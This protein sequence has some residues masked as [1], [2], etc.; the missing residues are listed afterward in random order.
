LKKDSDTQVTITGL[1]PVTTPGSG[2]KITVAAEAQAAQAAGVTVTASAKPVP[3]VKSVTLTGIT[4]PETGVRLT[5]QVSAPGHIVGRTGGSTLSVA[6]EKWDESN[7]SFTYIDTYAKPSAEAGT[8]GEVGLHDV[9]ICSRS[10]GLG[11]LERLSSFSRRLAAI[12]VWG[13]G[14]NIPLILGEIFKRTSTDTAGKQPRTRPARMPDR[15]PG[16]N[17]LFNMVY[18]PGFAP[19]VRWLEDGFTAD[20]PSSGAARAALRE[21][22]TADRDKEDI[23]IANLEPLLTRRADGSVTFLRKTESVVMWRDVNHR[24]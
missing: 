21:L 2:Q 3:T 19:N 11:D 18:N 10:I 7:S 17:T 24:V 20:Y 1:T 5:R 14:P 15:R 6:W 22:G 12:I 16:F 23:F 4:T 13:D 9:V 8:L